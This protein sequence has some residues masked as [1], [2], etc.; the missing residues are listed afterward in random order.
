LAMVLVLQIQKTVERSPAICEKAYCGTFQPNRFG[1]E[2]SHKS[3]RNNHLEIEP[4]AALCGIARA[5]RISA[6]SSSRG[7][8][9]SPRRNRISGS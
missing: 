4:K 7:G 5:P 3:H 9:V 6:V 8:P 1:A 2:I